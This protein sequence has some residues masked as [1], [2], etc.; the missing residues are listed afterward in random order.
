MLPEKFRTTLTEFH[1]NKHTAVKLVSPC[2]IFFIKENNSQNTRFAVSVV[3]AL[4]KRSVYR[5]RAKRIII[6]VLRKYLALISK[7]ADVFIKAR[8]IINKKQK[9]EIEKEVADILGKG[10]LLT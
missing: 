3:K 6:E 4:D 9:V 10:G 7:R 1:N 5:H 8:K 2:F